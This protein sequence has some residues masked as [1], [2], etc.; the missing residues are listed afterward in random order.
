MRSA[1]LITLFLAVSL[2]GIL[3]P[4]AVAQVGLPEGTDDLATIAC[5]EDVVGLRLT[6]TSPPSDDALRNL[7]GQPEARIAAANVLSDRVRAFMARPDTRRLRA[8]LEA[9]AANGRTPECRRFVESSIEFAYASDPHSGLFVAGWKPVTVVLKL[10]EPVKVPVPT[11]PPGVG[12]VFLFCIGGPEAGAA[13]NRGFNFEVN[14]TKGTLTCPRNAVRSTGVPAK[15]GQTL[16][17]TATIDNTTSIRLFAEGGRFSNTPGA[18]VLAGV[19]IPPAP[20]PAGLGAVLGAAKTFE[21]RK[22]LTLAASD[23]SRAIRDLARL[24]IQHKQFEECVVLGKDIVVA[25]LRLTIPCDAPGKAAIAEG[26]LTGFY[27]T[28][29]GERLVHGKPSPDK[30]FVQDAK[31][32]CQAILDH[33]TGKELV[34]GQSSPELRYAAALAFMSPA[35][36]QGRG[37]RFR[38]EG[39]LEFIVLCPELLNAA[40]PDKPEDFVLAGRAAS[41]FIRGNKAK[42]LRLESR[43]PFALNGGSSELSV[44]AAAAIARPLADLTLTETLKK[45]EGILSP[46]Q[47]EE[48]LRVAKGFPCASNPDRA[49]EECIRERVL[50]EIAI[51]GKS[52]DIRLAAGWALG[53]LWEEWTRIGKASSK[54]NLSRAPKVDASEGCGRAPYGVFCYALAHQALWPEAAS[55]SIA[56]LTR[57]FAGSGTILNFFTIP[58]VSNAFQVTL[59]F[60]LGKAP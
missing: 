12:F 37:V 52:S 46:K 58:V 38:R 40:P 1:K 21:H 42:F 41:E 10:N 14:G 30:P 51:A 43:I 47:L 26:D 54:V 3:S 7:A 49:A 4:L 16:T 25:P 59:A 60:D 39:Q 13:G 34:G 31:E 53:L 18:E 20:G 8:T 50:Q 22:A 57:Y 28:F 45:L 55:A 48:I 36:S 24:D 32:V 17:L 23:I 44:A 27:A 29:A 2:M 35:G 15:A 19:T 9:I 5:N 56:T 11:D 6:G 33:A